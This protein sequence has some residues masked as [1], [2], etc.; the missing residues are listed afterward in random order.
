MS[1]PLSTSEQTNGNVA[2]AKVRLGKAPVHEANHTGKSQKTMAAEHKDLANFLSSSF[3]AS[4]QTSVNGTAVSGKASSHV[5]QHASKTIAVQHKHTT[6]LMSFP[7]PSGNNRTVS[8]KPLDTD[9]VPPAED[10]KES[11]SMTLDWFKSELSVPT[12]EKFISILKNFTAFDDLEKRKLSDFRRDHRL[13]DAF[14]TNNGT[15]PLGRLGA[16][17]Y[18][19]R[20]YPT[21]PGLFNDSSAGPQ[22]SL[23]DVKFY[24]LDAKVEQKKLLAIGL[25]V[26]SPPRDS[27]L[28]AVRQLTVETYWIVAADSNHK[29]YFLRASRI[30]SNEEYVGSDEDF[31]DIEDEE[32]DRSLNSTDESKD[33]STP[34]GYTHYCR[35]NSW[36]STPPTT[37]HAFNSNDCHKST[38]ILRFGL[39]GHCGNDRAR[40]AETRLNA[41]GLGENF[42]SSSTEKD[43]R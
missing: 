8:H 30:G 33:T 19:I 13:F 6:D 1:T 24:T 36:I 17:I 43:T 42:C 41:E 7:S 29:L 4:G 34:G 5:V 28:A 39:D 9:E 15:L 31:G 2:V 38:S 26:I 10:Q 32:D 25:L 21:T 3:V 22:T 18:S 11:K 20:V 40:M 35:D 23:Y 16:D 14:G 37:F 27:N 12:P